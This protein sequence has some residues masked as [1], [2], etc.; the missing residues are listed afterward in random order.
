MKIYATVKVDKEVF[1]QLCESAMALNKLSMVENWEQDIL[2][3]AARQ[4]TSAMLEQGLL[5]L[6]WEN[7]DATQDPYYI[8]ARVEAEILQ[9]PD[10]PDAMA[11][12]SGSLYCQ[13]RYRRRYKAAQAK[14]EPI[15]TETA[16][17]MVET[18]RNVIGGAK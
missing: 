12:W 13:D 17:R 16:E 5:K 18:F 1:T 11:V 10:H 3:N 15:D 4:L 7:Y 14:D 2:N 9:P 8:H 6:E